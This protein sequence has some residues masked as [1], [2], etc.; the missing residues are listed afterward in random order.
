MN[1]I[2]YFVGDQGF[3]NC[4]EVGGLTDWKNGGLHELDPITIAQPYYSVVKHQEGKLSP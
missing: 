2:E 3:G 1:A 4:D